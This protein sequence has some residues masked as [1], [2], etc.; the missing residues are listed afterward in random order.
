ML[1]GGAG[2]GGGGG[3]GVVVIAMGGREEP[4]PDEQAVTA[5]PAATAMIATRQNLMRFK[6]MSALAFGL[7]NMKKALRNLY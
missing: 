7:F 4:P 5:R 6:G 3:G 1:G 2:G